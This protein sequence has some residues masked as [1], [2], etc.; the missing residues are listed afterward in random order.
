MYVRIEKDIENKE[1]K[2]IFENEHEQRTAKLRENI[3]RRFNE[4]RNNLVKIQKKILKNLKRGLK[5][6]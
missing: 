1:C 6:L 4:A 3:E 2:E 5:I